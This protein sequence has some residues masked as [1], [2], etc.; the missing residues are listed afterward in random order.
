[1]TRSSIRPK[2]VMFGSGRVSKLGDR[3]YLHENKDGYWPCILGKTL[4][5]PKLVP[6][7]KPIVESDEYNIRSDVKI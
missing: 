3:L 7:K 5:P 4:L 1:M 2:D 6:D